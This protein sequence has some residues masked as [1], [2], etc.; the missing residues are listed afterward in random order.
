MGTSIS[1]IANEAK[2]CAE[3]VLSCIDFFRLQDRLKP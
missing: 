3:I 1:N 2:A